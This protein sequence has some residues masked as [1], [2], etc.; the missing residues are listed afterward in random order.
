[1]PA[2]MQSIYYSQWHYVSW[3]CDIFMSTWDGENWTPGIQMSPPINSYYTDDGPT[4]SADGL[5]LYFASRRDTSGGIYDQ[6][7]DIYVSHWVSSVNNPAENQPSSFEFNNCYPNPFNCEITFEFTLQKDSPFWVK[8]Y[9]INGRKIFS[10]YLWKAS[11]GINIYK[12]SAIDNNNK[13][14]SSGIYLVYLQAENKT[15]QIK[16]II[17]VS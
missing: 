1:M 13:P 14:I 7:E 5:T 8:I 15:S 4:V 12:W 3:W 10:D 17:K 2:D 16:K 6:D 9:D 11:A